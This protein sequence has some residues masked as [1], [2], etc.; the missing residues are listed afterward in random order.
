MNMIE[1]GRQGKFYT[2][3]GI[4][5]KPDRFYGIDGFKFS[6]LIWAWIIGGHDGKPG[7]FYL[8]LAKRYIE[9]EVLGN[10]CLRM[11]API[12]MMFWGPPYFNLS[13]TNPAP[14]NMPNV[15]NTLKVINIHSGTGSAFQ[16]T[17]GLK[18]LIR[19]YVN[20]AREY[21][22]V[23]EIPWLWTIKEEADR[24]SLNRLGLSDDPRN[25]HAKDE[26]SGVSVWNEHFLTNEGE[27]IV[28]YLLKLKTE[29]DGGGKSK[30]VPGPLNL[31]HDA[32]NEWENTSD[33]WDRSQLANTARRWHERGDKNEI[34]LISESGQPANVYTPPL[35]SESGNAGYEGPTPHPP[36]SDSDAGKWDATGD[37]IRR[38]WPKELCDVNESQLG[39]R[40]ED[41]AFWVPQIPKWEGLGST[42]MKRWR[43]MHENYVINEIY[44]TFHNMRGMDTFWPFTVQTIVEATIRAITGGAGSIPVPPVEPP[45]TTNFR[46]ED[47]IVA[48]FQQMLERDPDQIGL[49]AY[50]E[51]MTR[52]MTEAEMRESILRSDEFNDKNPN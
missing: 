13:P 23:I 16:L 24:G 8:D 45:T 18:K 42:N 47:I 31:L 43:R 34:L 11:R 32:M 29:G 41:R 49:M 38:T 12:E 9:D 37:I 30:V 48:A 33:R 14:Y 26:Q 2:L 17:T 36:R 27:G 40:E 51:G 6:N 1:V 19:M 52:G 3:N 28:K 5:T 4:V 39:L 20:L 44:T 15:A 22:I 46:Y 50:N 21:G 35:R 10:G 7:S 25:R